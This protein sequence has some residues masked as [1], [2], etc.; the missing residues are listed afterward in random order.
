MADKAPKEN[1]PKVYFNFLPKEEVFKFFEN[2]KK[3][4]EETPKSD[5]KKLTEF[6]IKGTNEELK[7]ISIEAHN[8]EKGK[9]PEIFDKAQE[10]IN[11]ALCILSISFQANDESSVKTL[12]TLFEKMK[13]MFQ[14]IPFVKKH[15]ENYEIHFRTNGNKVSVDI[16]SV[17]GE[18]LEPL[19]NL[20]IDMNEYHKLDCY[21]KSGFCPDDFFNLP[22]E[23]LTFK[24]LQLALKFKADSTGVRRIIT[25]AIKALKPIKLSNDKFQ[26]KLEENIENLNML[27]AFVSFIFSFQ[28]D[29][30]ELSGTGLKVASEKLL[31]GLDLN[32]KLEECRQQVVGMGQNMLKPILKEYGL[33]D[34]VKAAN[35]DDITIS[36]GIPKNENGI[37]HCIHLPGFSK[38]FVAKIFA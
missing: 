21:L 20:G 35:V 34:A 36:I 13:P 27:N 17:K 18:F 24:V 6:E 26:K 32:K 8:I 3:A 14:Q 29:A 2:F 33:V 15:P 30:Q 12:E 7:G 19:V 1:Q 31:K 28:F 9:F 22:I 10:H 38:A 4:F 37:I 25:A 11:K 23:Q 16:T 5:E